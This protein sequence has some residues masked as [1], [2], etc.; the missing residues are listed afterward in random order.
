MG[1]VTLVISIIL[2]V[3]AIALAVLALLAPAEGAAR[4]V[5]KRVGLPLPE[6]PLRDQIASR[7]HHTRRWVAVSGSL[8]LLGTVVAVA[9]ATTGGAMADPGTELPWIAVGGTLLGVA[10]G[11][12]LGVAAGALLGVL[13][14]RPP[15][16]PD[17]PRVAHAQ[18]TTLRDYLD[19]MERIGAR[20]VVALGAVVAVGVMVVP[21]AATD[22]AGPGALTV[23]VL[24]AVGVIGLLAVEL[25]GPRIVLARPRPSATPEALRWDDAQRADDLRTLV[26]GPI[27]TGSYASIIG[28]AALA[29]AVPANVDRVLLLIVNNGGFFL[30]VVALLVVAGI[31]LARRPGQY[32]RRRLWPEPGAATAD[33]APR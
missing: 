24:A 32:Y 13:S 8:A 4:R 1:T 16:D 6:Q 19:P 33:G 12:L 30:L 18:H 17:R 26:T 2:A 5:A 20:I 29:S 7:A 31:A 28:L 21:G 25:G 9:I 22:A 3:A 14:Y 23:V 11:T 27:M 15:V 10:A